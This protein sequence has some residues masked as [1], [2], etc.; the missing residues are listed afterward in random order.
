M[1]EVIMSEFIQ[2]ASP[3]SYPIIM[4]APAVESGDGMSDEMI[5]VCSACLKAS[6]WHGEFYCEDY[7]TAGAVEKTR[8]ELVELSLEHPDYWKSRD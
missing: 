5:T 1:S 3:K 6:C 8:G 4:S 7:R 2:G